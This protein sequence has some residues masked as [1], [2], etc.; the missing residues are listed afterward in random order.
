MI[1][2]KKISASHVKD[3]NFEQYLNGKINP[4]N[5]ER[6]EQHY[7]WIERKSG[8][9]YKPRPVVQSDPTTTSAVSG[10]ASG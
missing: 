4:P 6:D 2:A 3:P 8:R 9:A 7:V 1:F 10:S 5:A